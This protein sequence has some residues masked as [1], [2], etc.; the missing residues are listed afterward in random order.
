MINDKDKSIDEK[1]QLIS[2]NLFT[3]SYEALCRDNDKVFALILMLQWVGA[4]VA[5]LVISPRTWLGNQSSVHMHVLFSFIAGGILTIYPVYRNLK[6]PGA[7]PN[8][9]IN[10]IAQGLYSAMLIHLTGGRIETH[11]HVFGSLAFFAFY[12]DLRVLAV[13]T[14]IVAVDHL[15]RGIWY[16]QSVFGVFN[17]SPFRWI[18]H[19]GWVIFED[20]FLGFACLRGLN[21]MRS[22]ATN[23]AEVTMM[24]ERAE[25]LVRLRTSE[26]QVER[27]ELKKTNEQISTIYNN[28]RSGFLVIGKDLTI[29]PGFTRSCSDIFE[30]EV[31]AGKAFSSI[32]Q[33]SPRSAAH[34]EGMLEQIFE[35]LMPEELN[36]DQIPKRITLANGIVV[37]LEASVIRDSSEAVK[38]IL[39]TLTNVTDL[40]R[41]EKENQQNLSV[42]Q[43][44]QHMD[45]FQQ[46]VMKC[47]EYLFEAR[48][49]IGGDKNNMR[50]LKMILHT[51]KGNLSAF[52]LRHIAG[53]V[54]DIEE[55]QDIA[56]EDINLIEKSLRDYMTQNRTILGMSYDE[57]VERKFHVTEHQVEEIVK[58]AQSGNGVVPSNKI[59]GWA[60]EIQ[61][62]TTEE[63]LG[64]ILKMGQQMAVRTGKNIEIKLINKYVRIDTK[65]LDPLLQNL[66]HLVRNSI[67]HGIEAGK[68]GKIDIGVDDRSSDWLFTISDNGRGVDISKVTSKALQLGLVNNGKL[69]QMNDEQK[70]QLIF[71]HGLSTANNVSEYSGRGV[72]MSAVKDAVFTLKGRISIKSNPGEGTRIEIAV[73][74][75]DLQ[76]LSVNRIAA[77]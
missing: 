71:E 26:L 48:N 31:V 32:F 38:E 44:L 61:Y 59:L 28:V 49:A 27:N 74:K 75:L 70:T 4:V 46:F 22:V 45:V 20:F 34:F 37:K 10:V 17:E 64:P 2:K 19:A 35:D 40:D 50:T 6:M 57:R 66:G 24:H 14:V 30:S 41:T 51:L 43:V 11:F 1:V 63:A 77:A 9:Y 55:K 76:Q 73:P 52:E 3:K 62:R 12:R 68:S 23:Q 60:K 13:G 65:Y 58:I 67:D 7:V 42:I 21:E 72:G 15:I 36:V 16:P 25:E 33:M 29:L 47:R 39:F 8:R 18:E 53:L 69:A 56:V 5:A 54:H